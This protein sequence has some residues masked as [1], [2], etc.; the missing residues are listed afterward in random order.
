MGEQGVRCRLGGILFPSIDSPASFGD[1]L[2]RVI[3]DPL[4]LIWMGVGNRME[5]FFIIV[6]TVLIVVMFVPL[7]VVSLWLTIE[8]LTDA[9]LRLGEMWSEW[10]EH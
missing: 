7:V 2:W 8:F 9:M 10:R 4:K 1:D 5:T 3:F 6:A